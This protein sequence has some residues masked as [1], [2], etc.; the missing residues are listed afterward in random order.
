MTRRIDLPGPWRAALVPASVFPLQAEVARLDLAERVEIV[1]K[2]LGM[3]QQPVQE[4]FLQLWNLA[5]A[6][7]GTILQEHV[8]AWKPE[9]G[10]GMWPIRNPPEGWT[11]SALMDNAAAVM[12]GEEPEMPNHRVLRLASQ[13]RVQKQ[14]ASLLRGCGTLIQIESRTDWSGIMQSASDLYLPRITEPRFR[15][16]GFYLPLFDIATLTSAKSPEELDAWMCGISCYTRES[17][18]D[19]GV[20]LVSRLSGQG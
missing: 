1:A 14:A 16:E 3:G 20:L 11:E 4:V 5:P 15:S 10:M 2:E 19:R 8:Q 7:G 12:L 17:A 18:E 9:F 13:P 6:N